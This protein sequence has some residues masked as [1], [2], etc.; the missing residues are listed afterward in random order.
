MLSN[1]S[2]LSL[3]QDYMN[4]SE[5]TWK[6]YNRNPE[7]VDVVLDNTYSYWLQNELNDKHV[8][9]V[10][11]WDIAK[12]SCTFFLFIVEWSSNDAYYS[13]L[14]RHKTHKTHETHETHK[15]QG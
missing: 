9:L 7:L 10:L 2:S 12:L 3:I 4:V 6:L 13:R 14:T 5:T 8:L 1:V 15:T 11:V